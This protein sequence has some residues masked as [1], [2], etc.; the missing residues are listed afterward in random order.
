[1]GPKIPANFNVYKS[2][3]RMAGKLHGVLWHGVMGGG[4]RGVRGAGS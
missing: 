2:F 4:V 1:M 3:V